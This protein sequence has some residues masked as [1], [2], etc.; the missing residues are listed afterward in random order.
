MARIIVRRIHF[1]M[2]VQLTTHQIFLPS[3][4]EKKMRN[5]GERASIE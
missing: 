4:D 3:E 5:F 1:V 2:I